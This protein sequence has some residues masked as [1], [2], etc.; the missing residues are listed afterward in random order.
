MAEISQ[1]AASDLLE[2]AKSIEWALDHVMG[3]NWKDGPG[4]DPLLK[5][6]QYHGCVEKLR[7]AR[8]KAEKC[9]KEN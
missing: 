7:A 3:P 8:A 2:A 4:I 9:L 1:D 5:A 6:S